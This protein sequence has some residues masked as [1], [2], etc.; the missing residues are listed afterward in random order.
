MSP[1][2]RFPAKSAT[3]TYGVYCWLLE[4]ASQPRIP[5][6]FGDSSQSVN[7]FSGYK[8]N[9]QYAEISGF[10]A[11]TNPFRPIWDKKVRLK[12]LPEYASS[13]AAGISADGSVVVGESWTRDELGEITGQATVWK[14][15]NGE[16]RSVGLGNPDRHTTWAGLVSRDGSIIVG[17]IGQHHGGRI[18]PV[19]PEQPFRWTEST[20]I[21]PLGNLSGGNQD[22]PTAISADASV[23]VG[24]SYDWELN[25]V[26][27]ASHGMRDLQDVLRQDHGID[28]LSGHG[29]VRVNAM[30][31]DAR[32]IAGRFGGCLVLN[33][34]VDA[35]VLFLDRPLVVTTGVIGDFNGSADLDVE[36]LDLL[37]A[38]IRSDRNVDL[39]DMNKD[40]VVDFADRRVWVHDLKRTSFG[41]SNLDGQFNS[42][43]LVAVFQA[44]EYEDTL[45]F[46]SKWASG[47]WNGDGD[48]T[49]NDLVLAFQDGGYERGP[50]AAHTVPEPAC[51]LLFGACG[52]A[53]HSF[54]QTNRTTKDTMSTKIR[55]NPIT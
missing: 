36:D 22:T 8:E 45:A 23:I 52:L 12:G 50:R 9:F 17:G 15:N 53:F 35:W 4:P 31:A 44:G 5:R 30:S 26:W 40:K 19:G 37:A 43:D 14:E 1:I 51:W 16:F 47:D 39:F 13:S 3:P 18:G 28:V 27:D 55:G 2:Y 32:T 24:N 46:N 41:D 34:R 10:P 20:G 25:F 6:S 49:T 7:P 42:N 48:F 11:D 21:V 38:E 33:D 29:L 54:R